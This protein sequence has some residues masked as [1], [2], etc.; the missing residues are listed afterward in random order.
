[1][2]A[3]YLILLLLPAIFLSQKKKEI[4]IYGSADAKV[5]VMRSFGDNYYNKTLQPFVGFGFGLNFT[6]NIENFG[7]NFN[8][9]LLKA[10]NKYDQT[11]I[12]GS[13]SSPVMN[14]VEV[15]LLHQDKLSEEF[16]LEEFAGLS[17]YRVNSTYQYLDKKYTQGDNGF[18][19][20]ANLVYSLD[21]E[22]IQHAFLGAKFNF[23]NAKL[24]NENPDV[25]RFFSRAVFA[26]VIL[27]YRYNF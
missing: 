12:Y 20:G 1:M 18:N 2:K 23:Y 19:A 26:S 27:G 17:V 8:Y 6:T 14:L 13:L 16:L 4:K 22:G 11:N 21:P 9:Y 25:Q 15:N 3:F 7:I 5:L 24:I 10:S